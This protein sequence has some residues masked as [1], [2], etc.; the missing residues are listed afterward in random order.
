MN[1]LI[2]FK[3]IPILPLLIALTLVVLASP[4]VVRGGEPA[5]RQG[6]RQRVGQ[7]DPVSQQPGRDVPG[8]R[9]HPAAVGGV[10]QPS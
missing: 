8:L 5:P 3:K 2:Q 1:P 6:T 10:G 7:A 4:T 9:H